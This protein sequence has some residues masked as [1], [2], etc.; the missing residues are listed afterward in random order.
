[1]I[2]TDAEIE[3]EKE[4]SPTLAVFRVVPEKKANWFPGMFMQL[5]LVRKTASEPWLD[6]KPFTIAS[7]GDDFMRIIVRKEGKFTTELFSKGESGISGSIRYPLGNFLINT[8]E[9][10]VLL[11][12]GAGVSAFTA[13]LDFIGIKGLNDKVHL[14]H[15]SGTKCESLN[16]FYWGKIPDNFTV[17]IKLTREKLDGVYGKRLT[18][19][20]LR[21]SLDD[22]TAYEYYI[23]GP[24]GFT[25]YWMKSLSG[26][27]FSVRSESWI[28]S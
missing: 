21:G 9:R 6:S 17:H 11:A 12:G 24:T 13:Y 14:Y 2:T 28:V 15:S 16:E 25:E 7:W 19:D 22:M 8:D 26:G 3:L 27:K 1:M 20:D 4:I 18:L 23:C 5:S 10:K